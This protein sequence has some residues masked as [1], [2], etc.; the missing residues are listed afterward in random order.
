VVD[1]HHRQRVD[2][3]GH[4]AD[5]RRH[6]CRPDFLIELD[7]R[8]A[9]GV[10]RGVGF[11]DQRLPE[12]AVE[13]VGLL[14][15]KSEPPRRGLLDPLLEQPRRVIPDALRRLDHAQRR[16]VAHG[17][18]VVQHPIDGGDTNPS[19]RRNVRDCR[20]AGHQSRPPEYEDREFRIV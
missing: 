15:Q 13:L 4:F 16:L 5:P 20:A 10:G 8:L 12:G 11:G 17:Q 3:A 19:R 9:D 2:F 18:P 7:D 6:L 1:R 14:Q